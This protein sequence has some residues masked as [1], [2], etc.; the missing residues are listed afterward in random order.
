MTW[1]FTG[2]E[3]AEECVPACSCL[4]HYAKTATSKM[5]VTIK[6]LKGAHT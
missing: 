1:R 3:L 5:Q 6:E 2:E 4:Q